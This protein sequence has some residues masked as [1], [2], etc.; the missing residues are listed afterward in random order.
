MS[1]TFF[2]SY[3]HKIFL[4]NKSFNCFFIAFNPPPQFMIIKKVIV[5][6]QG[7]K[8]YLTYILFFE[9]PKSN[10]YKNDNHPMMIWQ[11]CSIVYVHTLLLHP[12]FPLI[13]S[14]SRLVPFCLQR[15]WFPQHRQMEYA[16]HKDIFLNGAF[17]V[18]VKYHICVFF[19]QKPHISMMIKK[20][21][22]SVDFKTN[23]IVNFSRLK[24]F[25]ISPNSKKLCYHYASI[26]TSLHYCECFV[27]QRLLFIFV[28]HQNLWFCM[29]VRALQN[30]LLHYR[31]PKFVTIW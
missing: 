18:N 13:V 22:N 25:G 14:Q 28:V 23:R 31:F 29:E 30:S 6:N 15:C 27:L 4:L 26:N 20:I 19:I 3:E 24:T 1:F 5:L 8:I 9:K 11:Y 7:Y 21:A 2:R 12:Q 10:A 17:I 16:L